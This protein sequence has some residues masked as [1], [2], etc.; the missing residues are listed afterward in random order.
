[1]PNLRQDNLFEMQDEKTGIENLNTKNRGGE[2]GTT[3]RL[4]YQEKE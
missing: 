2:G 1:M 3:Q 4:Q